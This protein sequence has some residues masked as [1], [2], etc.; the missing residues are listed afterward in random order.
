MIALALAG[1]LA[2]GPAPLACPAGTEYRG[3]RPMEGFEEYCV[4]VREDGKDVREGPSVTYYDDG[5]VRVE[6]RYRDGKLEGA[7]VERHRGGR[8][9]RQGAY[10]AGQRVGVW[11]LHNERGTLVEES[12]WTKGAADGAFRA[13]WPNG[14]PRTEGRHCHGAQCGVWRSFDE[15]GKLQGS[16]EYGEQ[17]DVP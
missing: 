8:V 2:A 6:S 7:F 4:R 3:A 12:G 15:D 9:A 11:R 16:V 10:E 17:R 13:F 1:F 5:G 14:K